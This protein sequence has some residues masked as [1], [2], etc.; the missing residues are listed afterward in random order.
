MSEDDQETIFGGDDDESNTGSNKLSLDDVTGNR[1]YIGSEDLEEDGGVEYEVKEIERNESAKYT[2]SE[3]DHAM[4]IIA[5]DGR[6]QTVNAWGLWGMIRQ[7]FRE[8][9][10]EGLE[11]VTGLHLRVGKEGRGEYNLSWSLDGETWNEVED[12]E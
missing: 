7:A 1:E 6:V 8:A 12:E 2:F 10:N 11:S 3:A 5:T 9:E 4:D